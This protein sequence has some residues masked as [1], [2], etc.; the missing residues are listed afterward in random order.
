MKIRKMLSSLVVLVAV[1][2]PLHLVAANFNM[3]VCAIGAP[4][5]ITYAGSVEEKL[6]PGDCTLL[7]YDES[8]SGMSVGEVANA[9]FKGW[10]GLA[11]DTSSLNVEGATVLLC[12]KLSIPQETISSAKKY[13]G[14]PVIFPKFVP[15]RLVE[16]AV[17]PAGAG[18]VS[19]S[20]A[21]DN[22]RHEEGST[23][24][25]TARASAGYDFSYWKKG[26]AQ[27]SADASYQFTVETADA[28]YTAVFTGKEYKL[29]VCPNGNGSSYKGN[30]LDQEL[31]ERL[32]VG[33][34]NLNDIGV[35]V[36]S[37]YDFAGWYSTRTGGQKIYDKDGHNCKC[38]YWTAAWSE[39]GTFC[40]SAD[41]TVY[42]GWEPRRSTVKL[43]NGEGSSG[44][45]NSIQVLYD[46]E[47]PEIVRPTKKGHRFSG[48]YSAPEGGG[49]R[50]YDENGR[51]AHPWDGK[52]GTLYAYWVV[53]KYEV[54][55]APNRP[56]GSCDVS[57]STNKTQVSPEL[58]F[59]EL[60]TATCEPTFYDFA[61]WWDKDG[62]EVTAESIVP[63]GEEDITLYAHWTPNSY[64]ISFDGREPTSGEMS[65]QEFK[66]DMPAALTKNA[67]DKTG[68]SF[69]GWATN[70]GAA[71]I[72]SDGAVISNLL[73]TTKNE[74][75]TLYAVWKGHAYEV[76]F[77]GNGGLG[78]MWPQA[79][80]YGAPQ[81]LT[82]NRFTREGY[83]FA[84]WVMDPTN[85]VAFI[86][87]A[88]VSNLT[89]VADGKVALFA[90]W[91]RCG[92]EL[93]E[94]SVA[95]DCYN[96]NLTTNEVGW[97]VEKYSETGE[98]KVGE[99]DEY[100]KAYQEE[101]DPHFLYAQ[102]FGKG[103][104]TF[105]YKVKT[106]K[107]TN[108]FQFTIDDQAPIYLPCKGDGIW[109]TYTWTNDVNDTKGVK[110]VFSVNITNNP[111]YALL[112]N[113][114][115]VPDLAPTNWVG[116]TFRLN[117]RTPSPADV[118]SNRTCQAGQ[119][120]GELPGLPDRDE[121]EFM[122]WM[123]NPKRG[124]VI[125]PNWVVPDGIDVQLYARW[126]D[127][128]HIEPQEGL[129][130]IRPKWGG[131]GVNVQFEEG[132]VYRLKGLD[133]QWAQEN[134]VLVGLDF[135]WATS[136]DILEVVLADDAD[137]LEC[138]KWVAGAVG[139]AGEAMEVEKSVCE[140]TGRAVEIPV[141][142]D[143]ASGWAK[144][145]IVLNTNDMS[146]AKLFNE[147]RLWLTNGTDRACAVLS[148]QD[149]EAGTN[150]VNVWI[151]NDTDVWEEYSTN[152][153]TIASVTSEVAAVDY[154]V[155]IDDRNAT[156]EL[157]VF[158][159]RVYTVKY[160]PNGG[161]GAPVPLAA[162]N[163]V[164]FAISEN[165]FTKTGYHFEGWTN[166]TDGVVYHPG[167]IVSN[168]TTEVDGVY[169][170][171]AVWVANAYEVKYVANGG[172]G[173]DL[174]TTNVYDRVFRV[175]GNDVFTKTG[176]TYDS[177]TNANGAVY[178]AGNEYKNL[179]TGDGVTLYAAWTP[180]SYQ[181]VY[182]P[183]E[184]EGDPITNDCIYGVAF[185]VSGQVFVREGYVQTGWMEREA[186]VAYAFGQ[187]VLNLTAETNGIV[188]FHAVWE[189]RS[190]PPTPV[191]IVGPEP[192]PIIVIDDPQPTE[193]EATPVKVADMTATLSYNGYL[194]NDAAEVVGF[195]TVKA[196]KKGAVT[197]TVQLQEGTQAFKKFSY[198]GGVL[199]DAQ[200]RADLTCRKTGGTMTLFAGAKV[201]F[202][203]VV[204]GGVTYG[205]TGRLGTTAELSRAN[206]M[207]NGK[208]W[209]VA[210][211]T[212]I[213]E[214]V[215]PLMNGYSCLTVTGSKKGKVKVAG[216]LADG[217]K[218]SVTV[219]GI[220]FGENCVVVPVNAAL[221][222][223]KTGGFSMKLQIKDGKLT[224]GN[225]SVWTAVIG[226]VSHVAR[227]NEYYVS[228]GVS[229]LAAGSAFYFETEMLPSW[230]VTAAADGT[231][232][233]PDGVLVAVSGKRW[234]LPKAGRVALKKGATAVNELDLGK[235]KDNPSGLK[236]TYAAKTGTFKGS[237]AL[238]QD[239]TA[240]GRPKLKKISV[241]V[242]GT[243]IGGVGYGSAVIKNIGSMA[244]VIGKALEQNP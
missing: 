44:G 34:S 17:E 42:A 59:G 89:T 187:T 27:V 117:D 68:Y 76:Q 215:H 188:M 227:W 23:V 99:N 147:G 55:F 45:T 221:Y 171:K 62:N 204:Q 74:T 200:G 16:T 165:M 152:L 208:V 73:A 122:G 242:N 174:H 102:L 138:Q 96:L 145:T 116:V 105:Q 93:S 66:F 82:S 197:A 231:T 97:T 194:T 114:K 144:A 131:G 237:F 25:L 220:V 21:S 84:G 28:T 191:P 135:F 5:T 125:D 88:S 2:V 196:T 39:G 48:Y 130:R 184:G 181:L 56:S 115:W 176:Y 243:V 151:E 19:C 72:L 40:G 239:V 217:T 14:L 164:A 226:G 87:G 224:V 199:D 118:Y 31:S 33:A 154:A 35:A 29:T 238:Y 148:W 213:D 109:Q 127:T 83:E 223:R 52:Y 86:D 140:T 228:S 244:V 1:A 7:S 210:L 30:T 136:S 203:A 167:E 70:V 202:G 159:P 161:E 46:A 64:Y 113:I 78:E 198:A 139:F 193:A 63:E 156:F 51:S 69:N 85:E 91:I 36:R 20:P 216:V 222:K 142:R 218:V 120:I 80:R 233:L 111:G 108:K 3:R 22:Q 162:T 143:H 128:S 8:W 133:E 207:L 236:L 53:I 185:A 107:S 163:N 126:K 172:S 158:A 173:E 121:L 214:G 230:I 178:V 9:H 60:A 12:D 180:N 54:T 232:T 32:I 168:L 50:Y 98:E 189:K 95:A 79:F 195:V 166:E 182:E 43:E 6:T 49:D 149:G 65:V 157:R 26:G 177:W 132:V 92:G 205:F 183:G 211:A 100:L 11:N 101:Q 106:A 137:A 170:L 209:S 112:D 235:F 175:A 38:D 104:L 10:F 119:T 241:T 4:C 186:G 110:W 225:A 71:A 150:M 146:Y 15:L 18:S 229:A 67:F 141:V 124:D 57:L 13:E 41:L 129:Q 192:E 94:L 123:T 160:L 90:K 77:F 240:S 24:T 75:N 212:S 234:T 58:P 103:V 47:M 155:K 190:E 153:L 134:L 206:D 201:M 219:Q 179:S 169:E 61:G 81:N 37:G